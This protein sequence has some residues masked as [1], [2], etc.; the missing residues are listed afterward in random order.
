[1]LDT[2]KL[3]K[4][5]KDNKGILSNENLNEILNNILVKLDSFSEEEKKMALTKLGLTR[6]MVFE[7]SAF[8]I[9]YLLGSEDYKKTMEKISKKLDVPVDKKDINISTVV[10]FSNELASKMKLHSV[11]VARGIKDQLNHEEL[12]LLINGINDG[13]TEIIDRFLSD[14]RNWSKKIKSEEGLYEYL[15]SY[16]KNSVDLVRVM[17]AMNIKKIENEEL[18]IHKQRQME[19]SRRIN[20]YRFKHRT[21]RRFPTDKYN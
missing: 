19:L 18:R 13:N 11:I 21:L 10:D 4:F 16:E 17:F 5:I 1:M 2:V 14:Y 15:V 3:G 9:N 12:E 6:L 8:I 7:D 20:I